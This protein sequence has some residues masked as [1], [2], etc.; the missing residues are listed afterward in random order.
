MSTGTVYC[1]PTGTYAQHAVVR[2]DADE[3]EGEFKE[4]AWALLTEDEKQAHRARETEMKKEE[5]K[6]IGKKR[7]HEEVKEEKK[8]KKAKEEKKEKKKKKPRDE[9]VRHIR[10]PDRRARITRERIPF[11]CAACGEE[12]RP[13]KGY[14][15]CACE[16]E[17]CL[18]CGAACDKCGRS[19]R[20]LQATSTMEETRR[21]PAPWVVH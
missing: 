20:W 19:A 3:V 13:S 9:D 16:R 11:E 8:T 5:K 7:G 6:T 15:R 2:F 12:V 21:G 18:D 17:F 10:L 4:C 14:L 1:P